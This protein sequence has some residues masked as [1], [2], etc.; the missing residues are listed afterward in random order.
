MTEDYQDDSMMIHTDADMEIAPAISLNIFLTVNN[1]F[2][3]I[4]AAAK[5]DA[6]LQEPWQQVLSP[7]AVRYCSDNEVST[8]LVHTSIFFAERCAVTPAERLIVCFCYMQS[9][10]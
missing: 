10:L 7:P 3:S 6:V 1:Y 4:I 8:L 9:I 5:S 2:S